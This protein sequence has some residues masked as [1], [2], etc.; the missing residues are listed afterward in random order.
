MKEDKII[1]TYAKQH[2]KIGKDFITNKISYDEYI[3][4]TEICVLYADKKIK[5]VNP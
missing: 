4:R 1:Q 3:R 2:R 5:G